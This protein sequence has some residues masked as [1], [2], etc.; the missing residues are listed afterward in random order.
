[1]KTKFSP[2][3]IG[4]FVL[5][6]FA[7]I[8]IALLAF[9][10]VNFFSKP[11]RFV[12]YFEESIHGLDLGS[13]VKLNGVRVGRVVDLNIRYDAATN[14]SVV[15]VVCEFSKNMLTDAKGNIIDVSSRNELQNLID[16]GLRAQLGFLG[17]ATGLA[18]LLPLGDRFEIPGIA[19]QTRQ[20]QHRQRR[21]ALAPPFAIVA[22]MQAQTVGGGVINI[23]IAHEAPLRRSA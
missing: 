16:H 14:K 17:F 11:Q 4:A 15:A 5:G 20:A 12:V 9:G 23:A 1:M 8:I 13:P 19:R 21:L 6:A 3:V 22:G 2:A 10:G 7:L 18:F